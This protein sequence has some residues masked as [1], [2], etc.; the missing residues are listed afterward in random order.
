[1][2]TDK[3]NQILFQDAMDHSRFLTIK[4][5]KKTTVICKVFFKIGSQM[6]Y[7]G[8]AELPKCLFYLEGGS[9]I[10]FNPAI[11]KDPNEDKKVEENVPSRDGLKHWVMKEEKNYVRRRAA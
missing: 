2:S 3:I 8:T 4:T 11:Q 7:F 1:M 6:R 9:R 5:E 10:G